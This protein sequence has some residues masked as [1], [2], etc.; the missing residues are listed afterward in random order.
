VSPIA[1]VG[2][3]ARPFETA[4]QMWWPSR[5]RRRRRRIE[6]AR[7]DVAV[8]DVTERESIAGVP[9]GSLDAVWASGEVSASLRDRGRRGWFWAGAIPGS[10]AATGRSDLSMCQASGRS[11][12]LSTGLEDYDA[13]TVDSPT[14][15]C[16]FG[17]DAADS[18]PAHAD[19]RVE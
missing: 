8:I 16:A 15:G 1:L 19:R 10:T 17:A 18:G 4:W 11:P 2:A 3:G 7:L 5:V 6:A 14:V 13:F 9:F 12:P